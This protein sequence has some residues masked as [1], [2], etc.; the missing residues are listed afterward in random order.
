MRQP[1]ARQR[2]VGG[3]QPIYSTRQTHVHD[4][5]QRRILQVWRELQQQ[6]LRPLTSFGC[7]PRTQTAHQRGQQPI[8]PL[9]LL[10][11]A[12]P[13]R[14]RRAHVDREVVAV[15]VQRL[16]RR[17]VVVHRVFERSHLRLAQANPQRHARSRQTRQP[18]RHRLRTVVVEPHAVDQ[19]PILWQPKEPRTRVPRLRV[20]RHRSDL[21]GA[22]AQR[23]QRG[24]GHPVLVEPARQPDWIGKRQPEDPALEPRVIRGGTCSRQRR[25]PQRTRRHG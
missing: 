1:F 2:R 8:Q 4:I 16:Q 20:P 24:H 14:I 21:D 18:R 22:E 11:R 17:Q 6:R 12:Q 13:W 15:G 5:R 19:R 3:D 7:R 9:P 25:K 10:Q 23:G